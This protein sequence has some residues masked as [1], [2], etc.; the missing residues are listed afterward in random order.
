M[1]RFMLFVTVALL[2]VFLVM[3]QAVAQSATDPGAEGTMRSPESPMGAQ[4]Q[5]FHR[6]SEFMDANVR[7]TTGEDL[8]S[9]DDII[10]SQDG[11]AEYIVLSRG[12]V[13]GIGG[14]LVPV[15]FDVA[16]P[17]MGPEG[18]ITLNIDE[19]TLDQAPTV[20]ENQLEDTAM[21]E[22]EVRGYFGDSQRGIQNGMQ[23]PGVQQQPDQQRPGIQEPGGAVDRSQEP[24]T[25]RGPA[26]TT[27]PANPAN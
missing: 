20:A 6:L 11:Q 26:Q 24:G 4:A 21:W 18:D 10:I 27:D 23:Q 19:Q 7:G 9:I 22:Q 2:G 13:L 17:T 3:G 12:G 8:G 25:V 15:P 1:N 16:Q 5:E 14:D